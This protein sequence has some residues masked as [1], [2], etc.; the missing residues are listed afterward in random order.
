MAHKEF[1]R[2]GILA[3]GFSNER[4]ISL[5]SGRA[6]CDALLRL[7]IEAILLDIRQ[8][9]RDIIRDS[10]LDIAFIALHGR[11]GEDG[12]IQGIL[13]EAGIPYTGSGPKASRLA[14]DKIGSKEIFIKNGILVP[15]H[16][17]FEEGT[18]DIAKAD[19]L[20]FPLVVKPNLEGSS[21]GLSVVK[22]RPL[23]KDA[24]EKAFRYGPKAL[25]E[26]YIEG[27]ELTVGIL[28]DEPLPVIEIVPGGGVYD[29]RAKYDD[30]GT[31]YLVPAPIENEVS[32]KAKK[33]AKLSHSVLGCRSFSRTDMMVDRRGNIY[34]LEVNTIP[35]MT[36]RSLLPKAAKAAGLSFGELCVILI[37]NAGKKE[38]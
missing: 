23:L 4:E 5:R 20:G 16:I 33:L 38:S 24:V 35:G 34:I 15:R 6:V 11:F 29:Y 31:K 14:I 30:P 27:R 17:V 9:A 12:T 8:D 25:L 22:E 1:G 32:E 19:S 7:G 28:N 36:E 13:E 2:V 3:G 18:Y 26:E 37:E 10:N 21:I